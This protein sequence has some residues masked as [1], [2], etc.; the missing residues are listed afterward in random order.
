[1]T[2]SRS[3]KFSENGKYFLHKFMCDQNH[4]KELTS[5]IRNN[6]TV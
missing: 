6:M 1:M 5:N 2:I 4:K 3:G